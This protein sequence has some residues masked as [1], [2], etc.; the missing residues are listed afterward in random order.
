MC[1][2]HQQESFDI[3]C[4]VGFSN[5]RPKNKSFHVVKLVMEVLSDTM[6]YYKPVFPAEKAHFD[7]SS[8]LTSSFLSMKVYH[9]VSC[10]SRDQNYMLSKQH[11]FRDGHQYF[12]IF[13]L[14]H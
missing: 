11:S 7:S 2:F 12:P 14:V 10:C 9:T 4:F 13:V 3:V 1:V 5:I 8:A 6:F